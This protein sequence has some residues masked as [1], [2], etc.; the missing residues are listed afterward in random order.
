M[1]AKRDGRWRI[2]QTQGTQL[3]P[4]RTPVAVATVLLYAYAGDYRDEGAVRVVVRREGTGL[5]VRSPGSSIPPRVLTPLF[6]SVFF[7]KRADQ[8]TFRRG[9]DGRVTHYVVRTPDGRELQRTRIQ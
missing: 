5:V 8:C 3:L 4:D 6:D 9:P 7:D 2:V 1:F